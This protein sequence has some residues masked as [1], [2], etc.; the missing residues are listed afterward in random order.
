[1]IISSHDLKNLKKEY[2]WFAE[3]FYITVSL[4]RD[5]YH[6]KAGSVNIG[7]FEYGIFL[8]DIWK[9]KVLYRISE[10]ENVFFD[11]RFAVIEFNDKSYWVISASKKKLE[12]IVSSILKHTQ[13][14]PVVK[15]MKEY[16]SGD[17]HDNLAALLDSARCHT[18]KTSNLDT[19][20]S[21]ILQSNLD[22]EASAILQSNQRHRV[23]AAKELS[24]TYHLKLSEAKEII[25]RIAQ[26][27]PVS[28]APLSRKP[29]K[30]Q[31]TK[32]RIKENKANAI[33]CCP[34][35]GSTSINFQRKRLSVGRAVAGGVLF[36]A[37]GAVL[38][39]LSSKKGHCKCLNCGK[40]WKL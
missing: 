24:H 6:I 30:R 26:S 19:E 27:N 3:H 16:I 14:T 23:D 12:K 9:D 28:V 13:I 37:P 21:A 11:D 2:N 17:E 34:K 39:G 32:T 31:A 33:A 29:S 18:E 22:A 10:I 40:T 4:K 7:F 35:C 8:D 20:A 38:G 5:V 36:S 1:M 25:D 15:D